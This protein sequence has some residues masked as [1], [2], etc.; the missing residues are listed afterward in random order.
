MIELDTLVAEFA[1][2]FPSKIFEAELERHHIEFRQMTKASFEGGSDLC[3]FYVRN[4][5]FDKAFVLR[6]KV[7][8]E[9]A[10][11][12]IKYMH[13]VREIIAYISLFLLVILLVYKIYEIVV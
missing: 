7:E 8:K 2:P 4:L 10:I 13:P 3:I 12:E 5:D 9:N 11:S 1:S 6:E